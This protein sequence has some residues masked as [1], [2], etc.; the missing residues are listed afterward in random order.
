MVTSNHLTT[1]PKRDLLYKMSQAPSSDA[2]SQSS[3]TLISEKKNAIQEDKLNNK[4]SG[5]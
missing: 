4:F 1:D 5:T 3:N 2:S